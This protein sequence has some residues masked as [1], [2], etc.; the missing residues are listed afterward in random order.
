MTDCEGQELH[1][2]DFVQKV[3]GGVNRGMI[4]RLVERR[5]DG[6]MVLIAPDGHKW[7][8]FASFLRLTPV[9]HFGRPCLVPA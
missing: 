9:D 2:G 7:M 4:G 1:F 3:I 5:L 6:R 8:T